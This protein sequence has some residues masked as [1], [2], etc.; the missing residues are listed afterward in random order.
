MLV[1]HSLL[2]VAALP[3]ILR[4]A[5]LGLRERHAAHRRIARLTAP[6]WLYISSTGLLIFYLLYGV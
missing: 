3:L 6:L 5:F 1:S 4:T 2:A